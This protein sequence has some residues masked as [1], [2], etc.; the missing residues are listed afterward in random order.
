MPQ[1]TKKRARAT[2]RKT[3]RSSHFQAKAHS[4][5]AKAARSPFSSM[6]TAAHDSARSVVNIGADT[7][8]QLFSNST[9]EARKT[10]AKVFAISREG[11]ETVSRTLDALTRTM[12]DFISLGRENIDVAVEVNNLVTDIAR[13]ANAEF[14][15]YA[16]NNFADNLD[17]CNEAFNCRNINDTLE[18]NNKWI[19]NNINNFFAQSSRFADMMFQFANEASEPVN[20]HILESAE[21]FGKSLA[22]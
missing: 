16:N 2:S 19:S 15:K 9:E 22:A 8:K 14:V 17:L 11:S 10:H 4:A 21:R 20:E 18:I 1:A 6:E 5:S 13:T 12:N 3:A 7:M